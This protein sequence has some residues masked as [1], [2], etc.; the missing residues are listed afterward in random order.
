MTVILF[1]LTLT[2]K[3][4][5]IIPG[6]SFLMCSRF[7]YAVRSF[8]HYLSLSLWLHSYICC[9]ESNCLL[10]FL[11]CYKPFLFTRAPSRVIWTYPCSCLYVCSLWFARWLLFWIYYAYAFNFTFVCSAVKKEIVDKVFHRHFCND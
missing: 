9:F 4:I 7:L 10:L 5:I 6:F 1:S 8:S 11:F 3:L 2:R